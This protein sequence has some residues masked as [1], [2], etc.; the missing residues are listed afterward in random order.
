M[1]ADV[2]VRASKARSCSS[3]REEGAAAVLQVQAERWM[4]ERCTVARARG[5]SPPGGL[6]SPEYGKSDPLAPHPPYP[7]VRFT[8][9]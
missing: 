9:P 3:E 5:Q 6:H 8:A 1:T 4:E 2:D 7:K